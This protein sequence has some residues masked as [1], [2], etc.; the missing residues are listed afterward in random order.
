MGIC[1][2]GVDHTKA[3]VEVREHFAFTAASRAAALTGIRESYAG[4]ECVIIATCNRTELWLYTK[5]GQ[6]PP[7][8]RLLRELKNIPPEKSESI[9]TKHEGR[10]AVD[11]LFKLACGLKSRITGENQILS[12]VKEAIEAARES[13]GGMPVMQRLFE[14]ALACAKRVKTETNITRADA[15]IASAALDF[16]KENTNLK[17]G[18]AVQGANASIRGANASIRGASC[19]VIGSG[20][21]GRLC[22]ELFETAGAEVTVTLR[23][24]KTG[25]TVLGRNI[26]VI[27]YDERYQALADFQ[28]VISATASP[29]HTLT[30]SEAASSLSGPGGQKRIFLDL[31]VPRDIDPA[32]GEIEGVSLFDIDDI[33]AGRPAQ[34]SFVDFDRIGEIINEETAEFNKWLAFRANAAVIK[35]IRDEAAERIT[36]RVRVAAKTGGG[37]ADE[38]LLLAVKQSAGKEIDK[39]LFGLRDN[40]ECGLWADCLGALGAPFASEEAKERA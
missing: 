18:A 14:S 3:G 27:D 26:R 10:E 24:H 40:L 39:L 8:D 36:R 13:C 31:A 22:A 35:M 20:V 16:V 30:L 32:I 7:P 23:R 9:F 4:T 33:S 37:T 6:C 2:A 21:I 29:H 17:D 19:L 11:H 15:S 38:R 1:M 25:K 34:G 28:I 12:Q 5:D